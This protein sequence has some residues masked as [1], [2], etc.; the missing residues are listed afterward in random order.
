MAI[1]AVVVAVLKCHAEI[2]LIETPVAEF[3]A[4]ILSGLLIGILVGVV[5]AVVLLTILATFL[6][7][8]VVAGV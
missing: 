1:V 5:V 6:D 2:A 7:A 3:R 4:V 8:F